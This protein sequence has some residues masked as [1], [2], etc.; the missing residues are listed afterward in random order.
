MEDFPI[1]PSKHYKDLRHE[2]RSGDIL[3]CSGHSTFS[4]LIQKATG[5]IWSHVAFILR[6]D[7]INRIMVLESVESIGVRAIPLSNY[8]RDYNGTRQPYAGRLMLARHADLKEENIANLSRSAVDLF[9]YPYGKDEI[10]RIAARISM[11]ALRMPIGDSLKP[12]REFICSEYAHTCFRSI[13][14]DF[15]YNQ[16]GYIAPADFATHPKVKTI[17][18]IETERT[19]INTVLHTDKNVA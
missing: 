16:L 1:L 12:Q 6:I 8:V 17:C 10:V 11:H 7:A 19:Q 18:Y 2:I 13:G 15:D 5:S 14:I 9:G 4:T 3:L